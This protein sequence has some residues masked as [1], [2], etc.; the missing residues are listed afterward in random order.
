MGWTARLDLH[1]ALQDGRSVARFRHE[2]PLRVLHS[3]Y[4]EGEAVCH[5]VLVH[6]PGGIVGG[7]TLQIELN[8]DPG[9]HALLTTPGATR[10]YRT[11]GESA[12]QSVHARVAAGARLEWLPLEALAYSGCQAHNEL[13]LDLA[14]GAEM[15]GWDVLAL[16]LPAADQ[17]FTAGRFQQHLEMPGVWLERGSIDATDHAL[18]DGPVGLAGRRC[19]ATLFFASGD[20]LARERREAALELARDVIATHPLASTAGA[21]SPNPQVVVLRVLAPLVEPAFDLLKSVWAQWRTALWKLPAE[22]PRV[23]SV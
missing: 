20:A 22:Q 4:P 15:M 10:F 12:R 5:N 1:Y 23:W 8:L 17:P 7:D 19:L 16:G 13:K 6:P 11:S 18:L 3:L 2:G 9:T 14:P 21:T